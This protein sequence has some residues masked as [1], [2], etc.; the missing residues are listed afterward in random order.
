[1]EFELEKKFLLDRLPEGLKDPVMI[2]QGYLFTD[3]FELRLRKKGAQCFLTFKSEGNEERVEW[4]K[5]IPEG[6]FDE[7][8][9]KKVGQVIKKNRYQWKKDGYLY[10]FDKYLGELEGLLIVEI[11]FQSRDEFDSFQPPEWLGK[12]IDVT[13]D[14]RYKNKNLAIS[15]RD[16]WNQV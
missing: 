1:M 11:E 10:E 14:S 7:L 9:T 4:E 5:R 15:K 16:D 8:L 2:Q 13:F 3:P 6:I 12:V